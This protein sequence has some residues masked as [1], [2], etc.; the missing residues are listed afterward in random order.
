MKS[1]IKVLVLFMGGSLSAFANDQTEQA[2]NTLTEWIALEKSI[3]REREAWSLKK[4]TIQDQIAV[5]RKEVELLGQQLNTAQ[6]QVSRAD[7][8]RETLLQRQSAQEDLH[9]KIDRFLTQTEA[10]IMELS[11]RLPSLLTDKLNPRFRR[12]PTEGRN[13]SLGIAERMQTVVTILAETLRFNETITLA[14]DLRDMPDGTKSESRTMYLG[15]SSA[16]YLIPATGEAGY[17]W[18]EEDGWDWH[19]APEIEKSV[20]EAMAIADGHTREASF[21]TLP[22]RIKRQS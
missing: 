18:P 4:E 12:I 2:R 8:R 21:V 6:S 20:K 13:T 17:G 3:S 15:L 19:P 14:S 9:D 16:Y 5:L 22:V 11:P 7:Q 10:V 1:I